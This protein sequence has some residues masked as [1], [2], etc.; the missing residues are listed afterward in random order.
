MAEK[1]DKRIPVEEWIPEMPGDPVEYLNKRARSVND[2]SPEEREKFKDQIAE[3]EV[4]L[5]EHRRKRGQSETTQAKGKSG[6]Q[7][8]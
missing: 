6:S 1:A 4:R 2:L 7:S 5:A 8:E 3:H